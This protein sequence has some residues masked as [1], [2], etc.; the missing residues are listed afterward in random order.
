MPLHE[1]PDNH[2]V[3]QHEDSKPRSESWPRRMGRQVSQHKLASEFGI[4]VKIRCAG[5]GQVRLRVAEVRAHQIEQASDSPSR[6]V[7]LED[8][9]AFL[10]ILHHNRR[11]EIVAHRML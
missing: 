8:Y 3:Q 4:F 11:P 10:E 7:A 6:V 5:P 9:V 2:S 1:L